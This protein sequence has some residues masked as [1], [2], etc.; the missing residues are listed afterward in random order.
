MTKSKSKSQMGV[1]GNLIAFACK[2][3]VDK[4][5]DGFLAFVAK[6]SLIKHYEQTLNA[7]HFRGLRMFI[8]TTA[9][10]K[11]ISQYFKN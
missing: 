8:D 3:S 6:T 9:A 11:L 10:L 1:P 5:Y 4:G 2:V 7:T